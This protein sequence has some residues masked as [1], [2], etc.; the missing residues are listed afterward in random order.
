MSTESGAGTGVPAP[1]ATGAGTGGDSGYTCKWRARVRAITS[2]QSLVVGVI[3][4]IMIILHVVIV[5]TNHNRPRGSPQHL[6]QCPLCQEALWP[7]CQ[8]AL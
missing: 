2:Y 6:W 1:P 7:L 8:G 5:P 4:I 3:I